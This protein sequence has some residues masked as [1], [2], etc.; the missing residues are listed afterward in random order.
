MPPVG[1]PDQESGLNHGGD[2]E[3]STHDTEG[4]PGPTGSQPEDMGED[5]RTLEADL[6]FGSRKNL[7]AEAGTGDHLKCWMPKQPRRKEIVPKPHP[8]PG[9]TRAGARNPV[10]ISS[11]Q[12]SGES[13]IQQRIGR[14]PCILPYIVPTG[15]QATERLRA[16]EKTDNSK[17]DAAGSAHG[18]NAASGTHTNQEIATTSQISVQD[19]EALIKQ[20]K[21]LLELTNK[22]LCGN[23]QTL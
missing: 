1:P 15:L 3:V 2:Q 22:V 4:S 8:K 6:V 7:P 21:G 16:E 11:K 14:S 20:N 10:V 17:A 9:V 19:I 12:S 18:C 23:G 5:G 13:R